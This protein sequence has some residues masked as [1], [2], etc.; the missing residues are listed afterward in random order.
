MN[1][2]E[3]RQIKSALDRLVQQTPE[4]GPT[5]SDM[6][7]RQQERSSRWTPLAAVAAATVLVVGLGVIVANRDP[8]PSTAT[9]PADTQQ[10]PSD[11]RSS[12]PESTPPIPTSAPITSEVAPDPNVDPSSPVGVTGQHIGDVPA[13]GRPAWLKD[14]EINPQDLPE[15]GTVGSDGRVV[16]YVK[17]YDVMLGESDDVTIYGEDAQ[18]IGHFV[19]GKP[20]IDEPHG[21]G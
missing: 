11:A 5:P 13:P 3:E 17:P 16:G 9:R 14:G 19:D 12:A 2:S 18:P 21:G 1:A 6:V 15:W 7:V 8:N 10:A 20:V 4:L